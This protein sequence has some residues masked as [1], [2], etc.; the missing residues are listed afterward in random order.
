MQGL[1]HLKD[2]HRMIIVGYHHSIQTLTTRYHGCR[3]IRQIRQIRQ[4]KQTET[5]EET[6]HEDKT[7][8]RI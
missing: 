1:G 3:Q 4:D 5:P 7:K 6:H 8:H 2:K